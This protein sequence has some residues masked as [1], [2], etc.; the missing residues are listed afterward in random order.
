MIILLPK[1]V[2]YTFLPQTV[3]QMRAFHAMR[4][5]KILVRYVVSILLVHQR[6][7][8]RRVLMETRLSAEDQQYNQIQIVQILI[9]SLAE[10]YYLGLNANFLHLI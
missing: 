10:R 8:F 6:Q 7:I 5:R 2:A 1:H 4:Y 9:I 3:R